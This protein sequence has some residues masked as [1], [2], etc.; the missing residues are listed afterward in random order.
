V[1][2]PPRSTIRRALRLLIPAAL[3][4]ALIGLPASRATA[5]QREPS[6]PEPVSPAALQQAIDHLGDLDDVTRFAAARTIRRVP[7]DQAVPALVQ[8]VLKNPDQYVRYKALVLLTGFGGPDVRKT[9]GD[10]IEDR[11]DRLREV[12]YAY[13]EHNPDPDVVF[14]LLAA[15]DRETAEFVRPALIRALAAHGSDPRVQPVLLK[16]IGHGEN[17]F[18]SAVIEALGDYR[19]AYAVGALVDVAKTDSPLRDDAVLALGKIGDR[20]ALAPLIAIQQNA[21]AASQPALAAAICLLGL[22]CESHLGYLDQTLRFA[23]HTYGYQ[24]LLRA[25]ARSLAA[26][27][28]RGEAGALNTLLEVGIPS[29][30]PARAPIALAVATIALRNPSFM[31]KSLAGA[32]DRAGAIE[33]LSEGFEM[34]D[35]DYDEER[36]FV[37]VRHDYW[38]APDG[39]PTR[40]LMATLIQK[41]D[42]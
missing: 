33:L 29:H 37:A 23:A 35:N 3:A 8:A 15:L 34:V 12:A 1:N 13:Y 25:T 9:V 6:R 5:R 28:S 30:D 22:H 11:N 39:S 7:A 2:R 31:L 10:V 4:V 38:G 19:A 21:A 42:F 14:A 32:A 20:R 16:E 41:L 18:R 27:G 17:V 26:L 36:F 24:P 40:Q